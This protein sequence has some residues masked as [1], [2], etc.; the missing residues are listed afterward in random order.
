[1]RNNSVQTR[2]VE[3]RR[4]VGRVGVNAW[5]LGARSGAV[6]DVLRTRRDENCVA[7]VRTEICK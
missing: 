3:E 5:M 4:E 2:C 7:D 6:D 1:V